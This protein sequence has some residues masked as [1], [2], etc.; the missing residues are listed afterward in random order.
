MIQPHL[1]PLVILNCAVNGAGKPSKKEKVM[2]VCPICKN[3]YIICKCKFCSQYND[4]IQYLLG[5]LCGGL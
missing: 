3:E 2:Q 5:L 4:P 1:H